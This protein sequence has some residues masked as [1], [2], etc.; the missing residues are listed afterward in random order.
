VSDKGDRPHRSAVVNG[1]VD[2][3]YL[4]RVV[5]TDSLPFEEM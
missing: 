4:K 1:R 3:N 2:I 5:K